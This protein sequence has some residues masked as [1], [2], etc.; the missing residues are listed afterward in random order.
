MLIFDINTTL[1]TKHSHYFHIHRSLVVKLDPPHVLLL[2][3]QQFCYNEHH[4]ICT[5]R[6]VILRLTVKLH[7]DNNMMT[8]FRNMC[9]MYC[10][11][12]K[13]CPQGF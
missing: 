1:T 7:P 9:P 13:L 5:C 8:S 2:T 12:K 11:L 3:I 4:I 10:G 6:H